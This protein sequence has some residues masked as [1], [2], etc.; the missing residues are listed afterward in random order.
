MTDVTESA[1]FDSLATMVIGGH[2]VKTVTWYNNGW[3][4]AARIVEVLE[5]MSRA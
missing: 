2:L 3:G 1:V 4:Y 5:E